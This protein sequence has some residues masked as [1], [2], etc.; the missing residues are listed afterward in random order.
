[1]STHSPKAAHAYTRVLVALLLA[2]SLLTGGCALIA[3]SS[4]PEQPRIILLAIDGLETRHVEELGNQ[5]LLPNLSRLASE[6]TFSE[7]RSIQ[8]LISPVIWTSVAS[9]MTPER[10]GVAGWLREN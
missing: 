9:G 3:R 1:M 4:E 5:G 7:I 6:G 10:H 2:S 8:P